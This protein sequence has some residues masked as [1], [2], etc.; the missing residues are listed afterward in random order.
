MTWQIDLS[1]ETAIVTGG[2]RNIGL[3]IAGALKAAGARV[4]IWGGHDEAVLAEGVR[5]LGG[6]SKRLMGLM[7]PVQREDAVMQ[8]FEDVEAR[9]GGV[10]I[11]INNAATRPHEPLATM[12]LAAW[13]GVLD[14]I[15]T[16]AFLSSRELFRRLPKERSG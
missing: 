15:L 16:G 5:A 6:E 9:L 8:A 3:A 13:Q 11:L 12:T 1:N 4:C 2:S 10:S 7:V 14:V